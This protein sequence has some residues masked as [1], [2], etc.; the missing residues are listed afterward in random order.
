M[1]KDSGIQWTTHTFNPWRGCTKVSAGCTN[2]YAETLS[3]R[4]PKALGV[5]GD[6]GT[7]VVA[8]ESYWRQPI[9]WDRA[10]RATGERHRVFC[11]S[12]A[13]VF[14]DRPELAEPRDRL[15]GLIAATRGLDW[16]VLTKRPERAREYLVRKNHWGAAEAYQDLVYGVNSGTSLG[17]GLADWPPRNVWLG[18]SVEDQQR[19]DERIPILLKIPAAVRFLSVEPLLGPIDLTD[20]AC[21]ENALSTVRVTPGPDGNGIE[22]QHDPCINWVIVGGESGSKA[23]PF[24]L[25]WARSIRNQCKSAGVSFFMKQIGAYPRF[26]EADIWAGETDKI[27]RDSHGG[28]EAEWPADLQNCREFPRVTSEARP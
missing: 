21:G 26:T 16:L 2:C 10:A 5:W 17:D 24:D 9:A 12:L 14:E 1:G 13:D 7:R 4:N 3:K 19:A 18:V 23:R 8:A 22:E 28:D 6:D 20:L 11:A 15:F 25:Q 27:R